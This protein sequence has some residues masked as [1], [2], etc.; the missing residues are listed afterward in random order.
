MSEKQRDVDYM[1]IIV[2]GKTRVILPHKENHFYFPT[3]RYP[4]WGS[5]HQ[6]IGT[7]IA[8]TKSGD[9]AIILWDNGERNNFPIRQLEIVDEEGMA[10]NPNVGF[11]NYKIKNSLKG[12]ENN[13]G[14]S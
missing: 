11:K 2:P 1:R 8:M 6:T 4:V 12:G 5:D 3:E 13:E 14:S 7:V 9:S 10:K